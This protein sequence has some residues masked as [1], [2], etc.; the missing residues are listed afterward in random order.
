MSSAPF[1]LLDHCSAV[2][3]FFVNVEAA[4]KPLCPSDPA[5]MGTVTFVQ[6]PLGAVNVTPNWSPS[7]I[8]G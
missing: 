8:D 3:A 5:F 4:P 1:A 2:M 6:T 7:V